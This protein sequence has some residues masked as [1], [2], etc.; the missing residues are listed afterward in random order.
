MQVGPK[1]EPKSSMQMN[2]IDQLRESDIS[3][4]R[5]EKFMHFILFDVKE[6]WGRW[7]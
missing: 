6:T 7:V 2:G 3:Q 4:D 5:N 1:L